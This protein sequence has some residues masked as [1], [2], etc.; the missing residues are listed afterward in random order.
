MPGPGAE[1][2]SRTEAGPRIEPEST[3]VSAAGAKDVT[4]LRYIPHATTPSTTTR[5]PCASIRPSKAGAPGRRPDECQSGR[6]Q[7]V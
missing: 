2:G 6:D 5:T 3:S 7:P 1:P 4:V